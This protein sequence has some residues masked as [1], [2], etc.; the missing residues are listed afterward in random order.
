MKTYAAVHQAL[1]KARG[2]ASSHPCEGCPSPASDWSLRAEAKQVVYSP[3]G[4]PY[5][6]C[7][8]DYR[9]LC[10]VCHFREDSRTRLPA[11]KRSGKKLAD[12]VR[13]N[14]EA[15]KSSRSRAGSGVSRKRRRCQTCGLLA[16]PGP[17][18]VHLKHSRHE[19]WD[20]P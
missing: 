4:H 2:K 16:A 1:R 10:R 8:D 11:A 6:E 13:S 7:Q 3:E 12:W 18:G 17:M 9:P 5:S 14:P 20:T 15:L 19:G